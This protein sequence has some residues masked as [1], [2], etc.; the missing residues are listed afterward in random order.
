MDKT[1]LCTVSLLTEDDGLHIVGHYHPELE[2]G[3]V[4]TGSLT[5]H[6]QG[7]PHR[8]T[9][10]EMYTVTPNTVHGL[11]AFSSHTQLLQ[12]RFPLDSVR[13]HPA[14][15]LSLNFLQPLE[16]GMLLPTV[17]TQEQAE[18]KV[19]RPLLLQLLDAQQPTEQFTLLIEICL[20][21]IPLCNNPQDVLPD[22]GV[23]NIAVR[24][25]MGI[26]LN[27]YDKPLR[28]EHFT[29]KLKMHPNYLC[30]LFKAHTGQTIFEY[31]IRFRVE[32]AAEL[33]RKETLPI[34]KISELVGFP[35]ESL[36]YKKFRQLM[37]MTPAS[38]RKRY[39]ILPH[40]IS[41]DTPAE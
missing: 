27:N 20:Q 23:E 39:S 21:L 1:K 13:T 35:S 14:H 40:G 10:G 18:N 12:L 15:F 29:E 34:G 3:L 38:Y 17:L 41:A 24:R 31:L 25:C 4:L 37:G 30:A 9:S 6:L 8:L 28:L 19:L 16:N 33:L 32:A 2:I 22:K 26:I 11:T 7:S 36:F 5:V